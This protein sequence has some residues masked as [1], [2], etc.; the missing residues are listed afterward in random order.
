[1]DKEDLNIDIE[2]AGYKGRITH[3]FAREA[4]PPLQLQDE[5]LVHIEFDEPYPA[6][7]ISTAVAIPA[8]SVI[9]T[10]AIQGEGKQRDVLLAL[11]KREGDKQIAGTVAKH[12]KK[13]AEWQQRNKHRA[14]LDNL[15]REAT[16]ALKGVPE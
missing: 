14:I 12:L 7:I 13:E 2:L 15:A 16:E 4:F 5:L 11:V 1:M 3:I 6:S 8:D 9:G 10:L